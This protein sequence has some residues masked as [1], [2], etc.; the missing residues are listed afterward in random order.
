MQIP[1][2]RATGREVSLEKDILF[3]GGRTFWEVAAQGV[4]QSMALCVDLLAQK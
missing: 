4:A 1:D 3:F 2:G